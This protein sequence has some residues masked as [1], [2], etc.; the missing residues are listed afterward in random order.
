M[1]PHAIR[2]HTD[3]DVPESEIRALVCGF[4]NYFAVIEKGDKQSRPH[5]HVMV[6]VKDIR[7]LRNKCSE[8]AKK[9]R[10]RGYDA[11]GNGLYSVNE[12]T[13][14]KGGTEGWT[15][16]MCKGNGPDKMPFVWGRHGIEYTDEWVK[17]QHDSFYN[18]E[19]GGGGKYAGRKPP[20]IMTEVIDRCRESGVDYKDSLAIC[21]MIRRV[22]CERHKQIDAHKAA[23][24]A[25]TVKIIL[26]PSGETGKRM[27]REILNFM[28][29]P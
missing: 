25:D 1:E 27:D 21:S 26:D 19:N 18:V 9:M 16:Y 12:I 14:K 17:R 4:D 7:S 13:E 2:I 3:T 5:I 28:R 22:Y 24:M 11:S 8:W 10:A 20:S 23:Q 6:Y 15:R 29:V